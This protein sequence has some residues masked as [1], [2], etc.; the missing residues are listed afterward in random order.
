M[1][2]ELKGVRGE[3]SAAQREAGDAAVALAVAKTDLE[4]AE[5]R[6]QD[7]QQRLS[8]AEQQVQRSRPDDIDQR[9]LR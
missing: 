9:G 2:G 8:G 1:C 7:L 4:A 5:R 3:L 6:E